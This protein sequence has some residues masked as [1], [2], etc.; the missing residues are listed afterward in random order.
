MI[1]EDGTTLTFPG[2]LS[3]KWISPDGH[4]AQVIAN[5]QEHMITAQINRRCDAVTGPH[6]DEPIVW[7]QSDA[8]T[9]IEIPP[10]SCVL[11]M[12]KPT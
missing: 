4:E 6:P 7:T 2:L 12:T 10:L 1:R 8:Q 5:Y 9:M 3:S 11:A